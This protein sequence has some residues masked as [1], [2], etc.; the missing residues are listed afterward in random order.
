MFNVYVPQIVANAQDAGGK[1][2]A[3]FACIV[4]LVLDRPSASI[5]YVLQCASSVR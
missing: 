5:T 1:S 2:A 4:A 3:S